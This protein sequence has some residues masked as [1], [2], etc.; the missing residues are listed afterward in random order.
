MNIKNIV[1]NFFGKDNIEE[2]KEIAINKYSKDIDTIIYIFK[3]L[4][5]LDKNNI[6]NNAKDEEKE[7]V[8]KNIRSSRFIL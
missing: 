6:L 8:K 1:T 4:G 3:N 7:A 2:Q 5:L